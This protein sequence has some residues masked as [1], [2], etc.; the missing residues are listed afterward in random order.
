MR[1]IMPILLP[2]LCLTAVGFLVSNQSAT[3]APVS[4]V[5]VVDMLDLIENHPDT[6]RLR[7]IFEKKQKE[8]TEFLDTSKKRLTG[9]RKEL[10]L[11]EGDARRRKQAQFDKQAFLDEY[12][13]KYR[14][15][16][17]R[18]SYVKELESIHGAVHALVATHARRN[19]IQLVLRASPSEIKAADSTDF[20]MKVSM[21][22]V[23][24][25]DTPLDITAAIR[26]QFPR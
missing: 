16:E 19:G 23:V 8:A 9:L 25:A 20:I 12:D 1:R 2:L 17:A 14:L 26:A 21:R 10:E 4:N 3:A 24:W 13:F 6:K 15:N 5:A 7:A 18:V 22:G 11:L